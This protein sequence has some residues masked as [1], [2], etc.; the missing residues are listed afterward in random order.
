[1]FDVAL[2]TTLIFNIERMFVHVLFEADYT[3]RQ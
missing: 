3:H 1:M 2:T